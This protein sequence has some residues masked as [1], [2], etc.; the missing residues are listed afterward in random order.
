MEF[1]ITIKLPDEPDV[2]LKV[3]YGTTIRAA[4]ITYGLNYLNPYN[5]HGTPLP[6][7]LP[8]RGPAM[9]NCNFK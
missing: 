3:K 9:F 6:D 7:S 5:K 1:E 8:L 4:L 2:N